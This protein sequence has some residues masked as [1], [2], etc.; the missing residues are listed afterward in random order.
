MTILHE[1]LLNL[2]EDFIEVCEKHSLNW[3]LDGGSL[4][5]TIREHHLIDWDDDIDILMPREDFNKIISHPHWFK[6]KLFTPNNS[7]ISN[8][9]LV[10]TS[11]AMISK[12]DVEHRKN[13]KFI[14]I[15]AVKID[16]N[17]IEHLPSDKKEL[18]RLSGFVNTICRQCTL[19]LYSHKE[20]NAYLTKKKSKAFSSLYNMMMTDLD[21]MNATSNVVSY[22]N[23][24]QF[25]AYDGLTYSSK[26]LE[27]EKRNLEGCKYEV[28]ISKEWKK[29]LV[30]Y[31]G[32]N[33]M[34]PVKNASTHEYLGSKIIDLKNSYKKYEKFSND[35]LLEMIE[36]GDLL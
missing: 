16:I 20:S 7:F 13:K 36:K 30:D 26:M 8:A 35:K 9:E 17:S 27:T 11:T 2:L 5:G 29:M 3:M 12:I 15:P 14:T 19:R 18:Q 23:Y 25:K 33:Y 32:E 21:K 6:H 28:N 24:W 31:Y 34:T 22:I 1:K 10:D 4:L